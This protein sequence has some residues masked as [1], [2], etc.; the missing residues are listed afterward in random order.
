MGSFA[1]G[2]TVVTAAEDG[3]PV[4][5]TCQSFV[6]LSL[7]PPLVA[8]APARSS[9]SWPRIRKAGRFSVNVLGEEQEEVCRVF[10]RSGVD[11]FD[12]VEWGWGPVGAPRLA[13]CLA[14]VDCE[15]EVAHAAGDHE[16]VV[17]RVVDLRIG[18]GRPLLFYRS[19]FVTLAGG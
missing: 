15:L 19:A 16:L 10:A 17:G 8:L 11:K 3:A 18:T 6:A 14:W 5:F 1:T 13:G 12:G 9:T 2:V 4:G 7:D